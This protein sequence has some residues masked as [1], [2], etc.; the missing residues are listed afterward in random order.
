MITLVTTSIMPTSMVVSMPSFRTIASTLRALIPPI[1]T[2]SSTRWAAFAV[3]LAVWTVWRKSSRLPVWPRLR[4][5]VS[6]MAIVL[7]PVSMR[8]RR[9]R[10][11]ILKSAKKCPLASAG[12]MNFR[13]PGCGCA[14][15]TVLTCCISAEGSAARSR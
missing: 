12:M 4:A 3:P 9:L 11:L 8:P 6:V 2:R 15:C 7:A 1:S 14:V 13:P 10:P 5:I